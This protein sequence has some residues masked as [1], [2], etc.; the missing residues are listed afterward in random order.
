M[1]YQLDEYRVVAEGDYFIADTASVIGDVHLKKDVGIWFGA[2][3]RGDIEHISIGEQSNIQDCSVLHTDDGYPLTVG[4]CCTIGH[5]ATLHGCSIGDNSLVGI[6]A[7]ILSGARIGK[8]CLIGAGALVTENK[9]IPDNSL[10][11]GSPGK[12]VR[13]LTDTQI[14]GITEQAA[15]YV[16]RFKRYI[17]GLETQGEADKQ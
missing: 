11:L 6:Q 4:D 12:I 7:V 13:E 8:N 1:I 3:L 10:V 15:R 14:A 17:R 16:E 9:T 2:V 5:Q